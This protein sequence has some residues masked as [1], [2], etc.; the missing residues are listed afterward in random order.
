MA[1]K[2][3]GRVALITGAGQG[4]GRGCALA[5]AAEGARIA[6]LG[7]TESKLVDTLREVERRG[8]SGIAV[9]CD[10]MV[11]SELEACA[12]RVRRELGPVR[13][14][15][16]AAQSPID[17]A[18]RLL[19]V[20]RDTFDELWRSGPLATLELM[21]LCYEDLRGGGSIINFGSGAQFT[22]ANY[23]VYAAAKAAIET[24]T[25]AAAE[26]WGPEGIR[27]NLV[28]PFVESP[29]FHADFANDAARL[30]A[31]LKRIPL[32]RAGDPERDLGRAVIFLASD[33]SSYITGTTLMVEGGSHFL[34]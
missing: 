32:R 21:R 22:P 24:L 2:L 30:A 33:D 23:G 29:A 15:V 10:V 7:R 8:G 4:S 3:A 18:S 34:R 16:N 13:V 26:E 5:L 17:R 19:E 11:Q 1:G 28:V 14:L 12:T 31:S 27:A 20:G 9:R 6:A 25:R